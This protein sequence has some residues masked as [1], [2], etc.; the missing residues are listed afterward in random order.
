MWGGNATL[1]EEAS[2]GVEAGD[3]AYMLG[4]VTGVAVYHDRIYVADQQ[5]PAVRV[6]DGAGRFQGNVGGEGAGPGEYRRPRGGV[7]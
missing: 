7:G 2:I 6:Y 5:V 3:E 1:E 4:E